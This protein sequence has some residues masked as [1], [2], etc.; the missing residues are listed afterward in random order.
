MLL[1]TSVLLSIKLHLLK[2]PKIHHCLKPVFS[3]LLMPVMIIPGPVN[4]QGGSGAS[5]SSV[6]QTSSSLG[7]QRKEDLDDLDLPVTD[8]IPEIAQMSHTLLCH[9]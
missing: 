9:S 4:G 2:D 3:P 5:V 8:L 7:A 6:L 1:K